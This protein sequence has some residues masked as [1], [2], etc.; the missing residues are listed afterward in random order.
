[1][2][3]TILGVNPTLG[4]AGTTYA[5]SLNPTQAPTPAPSKYKQALCLCG[6]SIISA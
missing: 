4:P 1:L 3:G 5:P 2:Y 6:K